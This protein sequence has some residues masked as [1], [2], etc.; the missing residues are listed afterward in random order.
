MEKSAISK[1][2]KKHY[3]HFPK[4]QK[5][6]FCT[7]KKSENF[8][9]GSFK[10][11]S[12]QKL[13]FYYFWK[14]KS[15]FFAL[16]KLHFFP[17]LE[18]C[19]SDTK[20]DTVASNGDICIQNELAKMSTNLCLWVL[21]QCKIMIFKIPPWCPFFTFENMQFSQKWKRNYSIKLNFPPF[22]KRTSWRDFKNHDF[23]LPKYS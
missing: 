6:N 12:V 9:F 15:C 11:F 5:I 4:W 8:I 3:L 23:A 10:L 18:H 17:I 14:C 19:A 21:G 1:Y 22:L 20:E 16:L 2:P 13:I 7:R